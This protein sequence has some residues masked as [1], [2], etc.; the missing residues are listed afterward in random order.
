MATTEEQTQLN[1]ERYMPDLSNFEMTTPEGIANFCAAS[2]TKLARYGNTTR[3]V[4]VP[5]ITFKVVPIKATDFEAF[6]NAT[7]NEKVDY[8]TR[9]K[10][11]RSSLGT[12]E[13]KE[14]PNL[15]EE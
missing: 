14:F 10:E 6:A 12:K 15:K 7:I 4:V 9:L 13:P 5:A 1:K 11:Y 8:D 2:N 3:M